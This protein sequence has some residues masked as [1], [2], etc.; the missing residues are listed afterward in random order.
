[1]SRHYIAEISLN[2]TLNHNQPTN[3][4]HHFRLRDRK[5]KKLCMC[6]LFKENREEIRGSLAA[7][8]VR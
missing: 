2:V 4:L 7:G 5:V 8:G 3:Q 1:M 6:A